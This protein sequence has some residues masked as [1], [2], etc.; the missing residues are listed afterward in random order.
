MFDEQLMQI[1]NM[2]YSSYTNRILI[3]CVVE[4]KLRD[5]GVGKPLNKK[6]Y[7]PQAYYSLYKQQSTL[8]WICILAQNI[9]QAL[10]EVPY[11]RTD[12]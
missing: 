6:Q 5:L 11:R 10:L 4:E 1:M 8:N 12:H 2:N 9:E 7:S 3:N